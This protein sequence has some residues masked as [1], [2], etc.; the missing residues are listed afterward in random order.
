MALLVLL[1]ARFLPTSNADAGE[2][3]LSEFRKIDR[4]LRPSPTEG[5]RTIPWKI[6]L[7]EAQ[8]TAAKEKKPIFIWAMDGHPLGCT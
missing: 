6:S 2:L 8:R 7:L 1:A 4:E 3:S 5:W